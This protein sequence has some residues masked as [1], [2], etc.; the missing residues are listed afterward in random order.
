MRGVVCILFDDD[1]RRDPPDPACP[2]SIGRLSNYGANAADAERRVEAG[3]EQRLCVRC[4]RYI[5]HSES[6]GHDFVGT[7]PTHVFP[8]ARRQP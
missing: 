5:W 1:P 6:N 3:E 7:P 8:H 2:T 4:Q